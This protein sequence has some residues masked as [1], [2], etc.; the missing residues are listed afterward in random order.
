[1]ESD[2][3]SKAWELVRRGRCNQI[4][5]K[6][7][8]KKRAVPRKRLCPSLC[9]VQRCGIPAAL[10]HGLHPPSDLQRA[11]RSQT[12]MLLPCLQVY[13]CRL[14]RIPDNASPS[15][16]S[17]ALQPNQSSWV[18]GS[19]VSL[20]AR[21]RRDVLW[22]GALRGYFEMRKQREHGVDGHMS[23]LRNRKTRAVVLGAVAGGA[24]AVCYRG[25]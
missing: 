25:V 1:M 8:Q 6:S 21:G 7:D 12:P 22:C 4:W 13:S 5:G 11:R 3:R 9:P 24:F 15:S 17:C 19:F 10:A 23:A 20:I 18:A 16:R 2:V 14:A